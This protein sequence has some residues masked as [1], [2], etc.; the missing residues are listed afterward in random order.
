MGLKI[1]AT[2][3]MS[4]PAVRQGFETLSTIEKELN[5]SKP[6]FAQASKQLNELKVKR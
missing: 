3:P 1:A 5:L 4:D 6:N 2:P